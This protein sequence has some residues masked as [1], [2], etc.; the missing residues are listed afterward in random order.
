MAIFGYIRVSSDEQ[1]NEKQRISL[2]DYAQ[3][4][5][6][7][8]DEILEYKVSATK[9]IEKRG[10]YGLMEK[11]KLGDTLIVRELSRLSRDTMEGL[12]LVNDLLNKGV[13]VISIFEPDLSVRWDDPLIKLKTA[14]YFSF[15]EME[16]KRISMRASETINA[17]KSKCRAEGVKFV[18]GRKPGSFKCAFEEK[19][20]SIVSMLNRCKNVSSVA[21]LHGL[22]PNTLGRVVR[23][24]RLMDAESAVFNSSTGKSIITYREDS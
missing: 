3:K 1:D 2:L 19:L 15:A 7:M 17:R 5:K 20:P 22:K 9:S 11:L 4:N 13:N 18:H 24:R 16:R 14:M 6:F 10:I 12:N 8:I 23:Q 21:Y